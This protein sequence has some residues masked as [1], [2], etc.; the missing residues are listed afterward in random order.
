MGTAE[1]EGVRR[2]PEP[3]EMQEPLLS[4][5]QRGHVSRFDPPQD[6]VR[7]SEVPAPSALPPSQNHSISLRLRTGCSETW[8]STGSQPR[9][10]TL[11]FVIIERV[12]D[13]MTR[14]E[15]HH[16]C[17][18][19]AALWPRD[20]APTSVWTVSQ[21]ASSICVRVRRPIRLPKE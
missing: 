17:A 18:P 5:G 13:P 3:A 6:E 9:S 20:L 15:Q 10:G 4:L 19:D 2:G 8:S 12:A 14:P 7:R 1:G 21:A 16:A 11:R